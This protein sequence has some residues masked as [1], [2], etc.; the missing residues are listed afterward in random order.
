M[1]FMEIERGIEREVAW[2]KVDDNLFASRKIIAVPRRI[3]SEALGVWLLCGTWSAHE[4]T[5]GYVPAHVMEEF[6]CTVE[7]Y[8]ALIEAGLWVPDGDDIR[9]HD[10]SD[11]Q[12]TREQLESKTAE[13]SAKRS[14]AG[15]AG[16]MAKWQNDGKM[17]AKDS[18]EP[19]PEPEP[20]R[21]RAT[22]RGSRIP[23][24]FA[25]DDEMRN[26]ASMEVPHLDIDEMTKL[27]IDFWNASSSSNAVKKDWV[28]A[29]KVWARK[30]HQKV[31]QYQKN[32]PEYKKPVGSPP[33]L[34]DLYCVK[35]YGYPREGCER[36][37]E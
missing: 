4:R 21:E 2:F 14:A 23:K 6:G 33:K 19:E 20:L 9:F 17:M 37:A 36:C 34:K 18:P 3:R 13:I 12:P 25:I 16:A 24:D 10:W 29:W 32:M 22:I 8:Q 26:W 1:K 28:R 7:I 31:V 15:R 27:F 30:D 35:H 11:Y 5:D